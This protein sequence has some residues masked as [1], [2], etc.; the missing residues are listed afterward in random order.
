[1][2]SLAPEPTRRDWLPVILLA[3][4]VFVFNTTEFA[5]IA[6][7]SDIAADFGISASRAGLLVTIY[8]WMVALLSLPL[9]LLCAGMERRRLLLRVFLVFIA[10]HALSGVAWSFP[11]LLASRIGVVCAHAIFWSINIPLALRVAPPNYGSRALGIL[12]TGSGLAMVLG[13]PLGRVIGLWLGWRMTFLCIGGLALL[14][15]AALLRRL[16]ELPSQHAGDLRSLP[17]LLRRP[18][19][20]GLYV[21]TVLL[22]TGHFTAYT[23]IE[24]FI[25]EVARGSENFTTLTLLL[26]GLTGILGCYLFARDNDRHPVT[27]FGA[28]IA[29]TAACLLL[30]R[31]A[32]AS[33]ALLLALCA[34]WGIA[35]AAFNLVLQTRVVKAAPEATDIAMSMQSGIYNIGIG[36]GAFLGGLT[37]DGLGLPVVGFVAGAIAA[38]ASL[39]SLYCLKRHL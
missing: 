38:A 2:P 3:V 22:V 23:Y 26:F 11:V 30:L 28:P 18:A 25:A 31:P 21:L 9:M 32:A 35:M 27:M 14:V 24:P 16:P 34:V 1:M 20:V 29:L 13:L 37:V 39:W 5:P 6:L 17:V 10:S 4:A 12:S 19:L 7:L 8:A 15:M 36:S 33:P